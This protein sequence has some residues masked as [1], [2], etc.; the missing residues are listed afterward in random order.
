MT[1]Y[2]PIATAYNRYWGPFSKK[3][4]V[5]IL[6]RYLLPHLY[7]GARILD[8]GCG[9]GQIAAWLSDKGFQVTGIDI[10]ASMIRLARQNAPKAEFV[11][12]DIRELNLSSTYHASISLFA[13]LNHLMSVEELQR[14]FERVYDRLESRGGFLF[15]LNTNEGFRKR[16]EG[17]VTVIEDDF[18]LISQAMYDPEEKVAQ[19]KI[20]S[21]VLSDK[22]WERRDT[23]LVHRPYEVE[24]VMSALEN[25]GF[26]QIET[27]QTR[28]KQ[29][30]GR[31][32]F[33]AWKI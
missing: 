26:R 29:G 24:E 13:T 15:D 31:Q 8:L 32:F 3:Q 12:Q 30:E 17:T 21:F 2:D 19:T 5:P 18:V 10:S 4:F 33:L 27:Y 7:V 11:V 9:T 20:T 22:G 25:A 28:Y 14:V 1:S 16:W 6:E 23:K